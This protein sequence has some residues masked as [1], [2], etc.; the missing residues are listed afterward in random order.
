MTL[1]IYIRRELIIMY[2]K[3]M[4][5]VPR[6]YYLFWGGTR[7]IPTTFLL[8]LGL[9]HLNFFKKVCDN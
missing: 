4:K 3:K 6:C 8:V 7:P 1:I 2:I 9:I 5:L